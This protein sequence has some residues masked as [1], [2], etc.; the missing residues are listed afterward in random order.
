MSI[1]PA[2]TEPVRG[3]E[4]I[5]ELGSSHKALPA[6]AA[7]TPACSPSF[8]ISTGLNAG[9]TSAT[10]VAATPVPASLRVGHSDIQPLPYHAGHAMPRTAKWYF[11]D[12]C[13]SAI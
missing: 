9:I 7:T 1:F 2:V 12:R 13:C 11:D 4:F 6:T 5:I 10:L 8:S 3:C